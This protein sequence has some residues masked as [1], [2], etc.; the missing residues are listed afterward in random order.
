MSFTLFL[1]LFFIGA[2]LGLVLKAA[3]KL[4][5]PM[6]RYLLGVFVLLIGIHFLIVQLNKS[7]ETDTYT[8]FMNNR[9]FNHSISNSNEY[10]VVFGNSS[11]DLKNVNPDKSPKEISI[12]VVFGNAD[13]YLPDSMPY[14][15]ESNIAFGGTDGNGP[16]N[17]G[18]GDFTSYS[19]D[20]SADTTYLI[21]HANVSFGS[22]T[23]R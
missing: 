9:S 23:W 2:G 6:P 19:S 11:I 13:V 5:L 22:I 17:G 1:S 14:I 18:I 21:I 4:D 20:F 15:I 16:H 3:F 10:V 8:V 12:S 7:G